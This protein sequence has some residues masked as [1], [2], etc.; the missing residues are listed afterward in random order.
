MI[1]KI[2]AVTILAACATPAF[3]ADEGSVYLVG[4]IGRVSKI[5]DVE[6]TN[7]ATGLIGYRFSRFFSVEAGM[8]ALAMDA[9]YT[10]AQTPVVIAGT[11]YTYTTTS[12]A[13]QELSAVFGVPL[14][15]NFSFFL[16]GGYSS[17]ERSNK[18]SP[19][20]VEVNWKG[21]LVGIGAQYMLPFS[22]NAGGGKVKIGLRAGANRYNLK[23]STGLISMN[24]V[25]AYVGGVIAF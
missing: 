19:P 15:K 10:V 4:T 22:F 18:P 21:S 3:A 17:L 14:S 1:K 20:E 9:K 2:W 23:D 7:S 12:M 5:T 16:K 6:T 24:P 13:G 25:N 8:G 11:S